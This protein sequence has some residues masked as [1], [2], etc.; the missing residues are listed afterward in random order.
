MPRS[1]PCSLFLPLALLACDD[2]ACTEIGCDDSIEVQYQRSV[3][4]PY[5][6]VVQGEGMTLSARCNDPDS[7]EAS[8][9]PPELECDTG[10]FVVAGRELTGA[11][12]RS[13]R[14]DV[15]DAGTG[16]AIVVGQDVP[17]SKE[18]IEPNGPGCPPTCIEAR[19]NLLFS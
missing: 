15:V 8:Q 13:L 9:N 18:V 3:T 17:L 14:V 11:T 1:L 4:V 12:G 5:D 6:L 7:F 19:G 16:E 2:Q 10:G